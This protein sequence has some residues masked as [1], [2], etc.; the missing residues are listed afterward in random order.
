[1]QSQKQYFAGQLIGNAIGIAVV[2]PLMMSLIFINFGDRQGDI[3]TVQVFLLAFLSCF[4]VIQCHTAVSNTRR[5]YVH[6]K[7]GVEG[8]G[9]GAAGG[10]TAG[11]FR[12]IWPAYPIGLALG[13]L[14]AAA[15]PLLVSEPMG[16]WTI[17][18]MA[19]APLLVVSTALVVLWLPKE[20]AVLVGTGDRGAGGEVKLASSY[21]AYLLAEHVL[22]WLPIQIGLNFGIGYKQFMFEAAK[23]GADGR[24]P[25]NVVAVDAGIVTG[26]LLFFLWLASNFQVRPDV[27]FG[28]VPL[29]TRQ[30]LA[31]SRLA[32]M[33]PV[34]AVI[35]TLVAFDVVAGIVGGVFFGVC[36]LA[37]VDAISPMAAVSVK[38]VLA[39]AAA[40]AGNAVGVWWGIRREVGDLAAAELPPSAVGSS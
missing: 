19:F 14:S 25:V 3:A 33:S 23:V 32:R 22:P 27:R 4:L 35:V 38:T 5:E 31:G 18:A 30:E 21:R 9:G 34:A 39:A 8:E 6:G 13:A 15:V 10:P 17:V 11:P 24:V 1:V 37:G 29:P 16:L 7:W 26:I 12:R 36:R 20:Q 40:T 28:R 2:T